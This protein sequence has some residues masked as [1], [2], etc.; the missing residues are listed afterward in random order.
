MFQNLVRRI[1]GSILPRSDRPWSEDATSNAPTIGRKRRLS[2]PGED[3][4]EENTAKRA[5][6]ED[7][8]LTRNES[9]SQ[10]VALV[11]ETAE[12]KEVTQGV[13]D[14]ELEEG[15]PETV[16]LPAS[17]PPEAQD[18]EAAKDGKM[19]ASPTKSPHSKKSTAVKDVSVSPATAKSPA[20]PVAADTSANPD[21]DPVASAKAPR[22]T[23]KLPSKAAKPSSKAAKRAADKAVEPK[24]KTSEEVVDS[25]EDGGSG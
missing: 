8:T 4:E 9:P 5:K 20:E 24:G 12:V 7:G 11:N 3:E 1:S 22:K 6:G 16:P 21:P 17:P 23:R 25:K 2:T 14:V 13:D 15:K 18:L 10:P 19:A